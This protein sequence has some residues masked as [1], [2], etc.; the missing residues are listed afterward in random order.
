MRWEQAQLDSA[1]S[2]V[3]GVHAVQL[4]F[5]EL[6]S[7]KNSRIGSRTLLR[8]RG[9]T[10]P[11]DQTVTESFSS[12]ILLEHFEDFPF[13]ESSVDLVVLPHALELAG[14]PHQVLREVA[15]VLRPE[16]RLVVT[17]LNPVSLWGVCD[18]FLRPFGRPLLPV[19]HKSISLPRLRDWL[20]LLSFELDETRYGCYAP[21]FRKQGSLDQ[22]A[23]M[24]RF[25]DRW[26]PIC[27]S[28]YRV[29]AV[30]RVR[31]M[32]LLGPV[33]RNEAHRRRAAVVASPRFEGEAAAP[34]PPSYNKPPQ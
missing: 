4:G 10:T 9:D 22:S 14:D 30:K 32:R 34:A 18:V 1:V 27:G 8:R 20:R 29:A 31:G 3:F 25:G 13:E 15:R 24:E 19:Q 16:G 26:W 5:A 28:V 12:Q 2:D 21:P 7:L 11:S 17:G 23:F 33:W 6:S